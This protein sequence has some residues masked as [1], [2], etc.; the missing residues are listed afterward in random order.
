MGVPRVWGVLELGLGCPRARFGGSK[1]L[2][3]PGVCHI[4]EPRSGRSQGLGCPRAEF[5]GFL[6]FS[7]S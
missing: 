7:M 4:L 5:G 6:G 2:G 1:G 3:C